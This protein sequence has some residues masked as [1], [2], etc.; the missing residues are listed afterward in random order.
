MTTGLMRAI[1][2]RFFLYVRPPCIKLA[3]EVRVRF[4]GWMAETKTIALNLVRGLIGPFSRFINKLPKPLYKPLQV[5]FVG[6]GCLIFILVSLVFYVRF[7]TFDFSEKEIDKFLNF[8]PAASVQ[9]IDASGEALFELPGI[10]N[11]EDRVPYYRH[12]VNV[13]EIPEVVIEALLAAEDK[14]F[15]FHSGVDFLAVFR[16]V[17]SVARS[18]VSASISS[19][20][21]K[22]VYSQG[23]S[24]WDQ[25]MIRQVFFQEDFEREQR[26]RTNKIGKLFRKIKEV[27]FALWLERKLLDRYKD[28]ELAKMKILE[29]FATMGFCGHGQYG[30]A[31]C[32]KFYFGKELRE[33]KA[34]EEAALLAGL[35][36][37]PAGYSPIN[38]PEIALSRRNTVL[39]QMVK[40][41]GKKEYEEAKK[42][43]VVLMKR[44]WPQ[45]KF[46]AASAVNYILKTLWG[47]QE[48]PLITW[49]NGVTV[50]STIVKSFQQP[51]SAAVE[52]GLS[53]YQKRHP[54]P[55]PKAQAAFVVMRNNGE[56]LAM[57]GGANP[58]YTD[59]NRVTSQRQPGSA[60]KPVIYFAAL[61]NGKR[62]DCTRE[63]P[64]CY[65]L[66]RPIG[67]NMGGG[68][69]HEVHNYD[70][71]YFGF[72]QMWQCLAESRNACTMWL[73]N[74]IVPEGKL[75]SL[76]AIKEAANLL[77]L[78]DD[79]PLYPTIA[80]G[81]EVTTP[82][83]LTVAY[84][85]FANG[86]YKVVPTIYHQ[87]LQADKTIIKEATL[88]H[89]RVMSEEEAQKMAVLL[90]HAV[91]WQ[92]GTGRSL[93]NVPNWEGKI[94]FPFE[95]AGKT[96]TTNNF[97]DAW[98]CGSTYGLRGITACVWVGN[99]DNVSL[100]DP[101]KC[102]PVDYE[103]RRYCDSG[104]AVALPIFKKFMELVYGSGFAP[105]PFPVEVNNQVRS[106]HR[107]GVVVSAPTKEPE[108]K[109]EPVKNTPIPALDPKSEVAKEE[110]KSG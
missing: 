54:D 32:A 19:R 55:S 35:L 47:S 45:E 83:A 13:G 57:V 8:N 81:A 22:I 38:H 42:K 87:V 11:W 26:G 106:A 75:E 69:Y 71:R 109:S 80:L 76:K 78:Y 91:I 66:D 58:R 95:I 30:M 49:E 96:G 98:F 44:S 108:K 92:S 16:A 100:T 36:P 67:I 28:Q 102:N 51:A 93:S 48:Q 105:D 97:L 89:E 46:V 33:I 9:I 88:Y 23:A 29:V 21:P 68:R 17:W 37:N 99:D 1:K 25:Q 82:L 64:D 107:F 50:K 31:S 72:V 104:A 3:G 40:L 94:A 85:A 60:I 101:A 18:S 70:G 61:K 103:G 4:P 73:A 52:H 63:N 7:W 56:I 12:P 59:F 39:D 65:V 53:E 14:R 77:G 62:I 90:R 5:L 110:K 86:G 43:P 41:T 15:F 2:E 10:E 34:P 24:S 27:R 84:A 74:R 79:A 20:W 6:S